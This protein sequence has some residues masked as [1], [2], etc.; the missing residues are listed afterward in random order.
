LAN[1]ATSEYLADPNTNNPNEKHFCLYQ[2]WSSGGSGMVLT[3]NVMVERLCKE[4]SRNV[5]LDKM[6]DLST[7][8]TWAK[9]FKQN[10]DQQQEDALSIM[11]IN[12]AGRQSP[13]ASTGLLNRPISISGG[14]NSRLLLPG[15]LGKILGWFLFLTPKKMD[16]HEIQKVTAQFVTSAKLAKETG[17]DGVQIHAAHGYLLAQSLSPNGNLRNDNYGGTPEGRRKLLLE[18]IPAVREAVGKDFVL[19]VKL[20]TKDRRND[21][22]DRE[23]ECIDLIA[24]LSDL[25]QLDFIELSGGSFED[26]FL[27]S[28]A[29]QGTHQP[30]AHRLHSAMQ[31]SPKEAKNMPRI[32]LTGGFRSA[33]DMSNALEL[34]MADFIG[35]GR[36][37]CVNPSFPHDILTGKQKLMKDVP[38]DTYFAKALLE[39]VLNALWY[40]RQIDLLSQN[41]EF[42]P[43]LSILSTLIFLFF[44]TYI[45]DWK[46]M[47][48]HAPATS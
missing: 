7:F 9:S 46:T 44:K 25:K 13:L 10:G 38:L 34:G 15:L 12:H 45:W 23:N 28:S 20:N 19:G 43:K 2:R 48:Y 42:D 33:A 11:Q 39:P 8:R 37:C 5:V 30:F 21:G 35:L 14:W 47:F 40:Q 31:K 1:A 18:I 4:N 6:S 3:G 27:L 41:K 36:P 16:W 22:L 17:F 32:M 24:K 29:G 26:F